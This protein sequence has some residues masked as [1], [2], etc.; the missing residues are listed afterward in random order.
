[1][2]VKYIEICAFSDGPD[3]KFHIKQK[4]ISSKITLLNIKSASRAAFFIVVMFPN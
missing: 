1:M 2:H 3:K 4:T